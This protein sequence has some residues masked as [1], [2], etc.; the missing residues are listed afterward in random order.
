M[1]F[2][3]FDLAAGGWAAALDRLPGGLVCHT[4]PW[5]EFLRASQHGEPVAALLHDDGEPIGAFA[6]MIVRRMGL[7]LLGSPFAGWTTPYMGLDL[8]PG[9]SRQDALRALVAFA[10]NDLGCV[11][12]EMMDR[13]LELDDLQDLTYQHRMF[14]TWEV[15]LQD[16][17]DAL[18]ATFS[19]SGRRFYRKAIA[20]GLTV[21]VA[22]DDAF[23]HDYYDQLTDV[24]ARQ[25]LVPT[26]PRARVEALLAHLPAEQILRLRVRKPDGAPAATGLFHAVD[27]LRVYGWGF[28]SYRVDQPLHPNELLMVEAMRRWR[29]RGFRIMDLGGDGEYKRRYHPRRVSVPWIRISRYP[30]L[31][32]LREA[33]RRGYVVRQRALG[34]LPSHQRTVGRPGDEPDDAEEGMTD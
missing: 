22:D 18:L 9:V 25:Q 8:A 30:F 27:P 21:E 23:V 20:N 15:D 16:S 1:H 4:T 34:R 31:P 3:R 2:E 17:D 29:E 33:A 26:Y 13:H 6:G 7:R 5:L 11:H 32:P 10:W 28:A 14:N 19:T 12:L 24:F